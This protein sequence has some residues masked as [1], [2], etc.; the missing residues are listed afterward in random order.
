[1]YS[2]N[3]SRTDS[4]KL[5]SGFWSPARKGTPTWT[6]PWWCWR[7]MRIEVVAVGN[8]RNQLNQGGFWLAAQRSEPAAGD[9][10]CLAFESWRCARMHC[11]TMSY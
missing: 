7:R 6:W 11:A 10:E 9:G 5:A 8:L 2:K 4:A 1:M 3:V